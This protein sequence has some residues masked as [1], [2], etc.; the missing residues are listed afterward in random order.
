MI[1]RSLADEIRLAAKEFPVVTISGP[2]QTGKTTLVKSLFPDKPYINL[3]APNVR[4]RII[5]DPVNF[6]ASHPNGAIIDEV[7]N[8]P[9]MTSYIQVAV[10][11][12]QKTGKYILTGSHQFELYKHISQS[13]AGRNSLQTLLPL[14][15]SELINANYDLDIDDYLFNGFFPRIYSHNIRPPSFYSYYITTYLERD[16]HNLLNVK[17]LRAF[18]HFMRVCASRCGQIIKF[19]ELANEV[20][21]S[22]TTIKN[23]LSVLES[24]YIIVLL[25][26]YFENFGKRLLKNPK[27]YFVDIGLAGYLLEN[28]EKRQISRDPLRGNLFENLVVMEIIK[29]RLNR[30]QHSPIY[31][32]RDSNGNEVDVIIKQG[33]LLIPIEIKSSKTFSKSF[34]KGLQY[35]QKLI[36][37]RC[38]QASIVYGGDETS[39]VADQQLVSY[40]N[41]AKCLD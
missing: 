36:G 19:E 31:F 32:F 37:N 34:T 35:F 8:Y 29:H 12:H 25:Q 28:E 26:P 33:N 21:V 16:L 1:E 6:L 41:I 40:K 13:L 10:D 14:S 17:D 4:N 23:W 39:K 20:G 22:A 27:L 18:R 3:E 9:D 24:S 15:I 11:E 30:G 38:G 2:R 5:A 7:Q